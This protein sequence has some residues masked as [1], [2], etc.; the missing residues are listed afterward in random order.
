MRYTAL[1]N[2]EPD[3]GA[4]SVTV[5]AMPGVLTWGRTPVEASKSA[6]EAIEL[7][8]EGF[9]ERGL[10][11]PADRVPRRRSSWRTR[12]SVNGSRGRERHAASLAMVDVRIPA[13]TI[14]DS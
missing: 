7:H 13:R 12:P 2:S 9:V 11:I 14:S 4:V 6:R 1:L 3:G 8:L 10:P 5:P